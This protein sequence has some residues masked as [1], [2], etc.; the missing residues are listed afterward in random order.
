MKKFYLISLIILAVLM[1]FSYC[2]KDDDVEQ[3][4]SEGT[5]TIENIASIKIPSGV[6]STAQNVTLEKTNNT[7]SQ[8]IFNEYSEFYR[9]SPCLPYEVRITC[10][11]MPNSDEI[12]IQ[13]NVP[14][15]FI[16]SVPQGYG[17]ELFAQVYQD[18]GEEIL[19]NFEILTSSYDEDLEI[20]TAKL[21]KYIFTN[22]RTNGKFEAILTIAATPGISNQATQKAATLD[23]CQAASISCPIGSCKVSS[24]YNPLIRNIPELK[25]S[26]P[27]LGVDFSTD[28][29]VGLPVK[30]VSDGVIELV[31]VNPGGYGLYIIVRHDNGSASLYA[32]LSASSYSIGS[33]GQKVKNG[34]Q[35]GKSGG[36]KGN[37]YSGSSTGSH[38][39]FEYVPNGQIF[40]KKNKIDPFPCINNNSTE[41][42]FR[43][44][45]V[46]GDDQTCSFDSSP[47]NPIVFQIYEANE[48]NI[49][50]LPIRLI[51][52]AVGKWNPSIGY[53]NDTLSNQVRNTDINGRIIVTDWILSGKGLG[54]SF[55]N[56]GQTHLLHAF[57]DLPSYP[58][59]HA[60]AS[61]RAVC[62]ELPFKYVISIEECTSCS[63][64]EYSIKAIATVTGGVPPY[65][66]EIN[67]PCYANDVYSNTNILATPCCN[68][69]D[70]AFVCPCFIDSSYKVGTNSY[71]M[72]N[73]GCW[74][75][76]QYENN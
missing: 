59:V 3:K 32:H 43:I 47:S 10:E 69:C 34:Q 72:D 40:N 16:Y 46:E 70:C 39:H 51:S 42:D 12:E 13:L 28:G 48:G 63:A 71:I 31:K 57:L 27:H 49:V 22:A 7:N 15:D 8:T 65:T 68:I 73:R 41:S 20:L 1:V 35:I 61:A 66:G 54:H 4:I 9:A 45:L 74:V 76:Q 11:T 5:K 23:A 2:Q 62:S 30:S 64:Y 55:S 60:V 29:T 6:F 36:A 52:I 56:N 58:E 38:L 75:S 33:S 37:P 24:P 25:Q 67:L 17:I 18:S 26:R 19:D 50:N 44:S 14:D 53:H 21:P